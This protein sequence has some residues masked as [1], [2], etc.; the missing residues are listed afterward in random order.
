MKIVDK[1]ESI[2]DSLWAVQTEDK[3]P[4]KNVICLFSVILMVPMK[5]KKALNFFLL[6]VWRIS[7]YWDKQKWALL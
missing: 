6:R 3:S 7:S 1:N 4:L 5:I 2:K